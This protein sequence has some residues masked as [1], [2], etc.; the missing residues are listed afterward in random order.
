MITV[1]AS[2]TTE[3]GKS[4]FKTC[5]LLDLPGPFRITDNPKAL[6]H[7]S[8]TYTP[9]DGII[10]SA[11]DVNRQRELSSDSYEIGLDA[12]NLGIYQDYVTNNRV[13]AS[14]TMSL[15]FVDSTY[16]IINSDAVVM[17]YK[18]LVDSWSL[19]E[20]GSKAEFSIRVTSHWSAFKIRRGRYT[21]TASQEEFYP[22]DTLF[23]FSFQEEL[24]IRW[25]L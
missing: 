14:V 2:V 25:G 21:N 17:L 16:N 1:P 5:L 6:T 20:Q 23:E 7:N 10:M 18:G 13:G 4:T 9:A 22:G 12:T 8:L 15:A 19:S 24:P 11:G 3:L